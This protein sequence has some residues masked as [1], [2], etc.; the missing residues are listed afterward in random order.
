MPAGTVLG[1]AFVLA[2]LLGTTGCSSTQTGIWQ[3]PV[4]PNRPEATFNATA[5]Q[6]GPSTAP[7]NECKGSYAGAYGSGAYAPG[8]ARTGAGSAPVGW[9]NYRLGTGDKIRV[10]VLQDSEFS[11]DY[12]VDQTGHVSARMLGP[13]R[14]AGMTTDDLAA[15][16]RD[17]YKASGYLVAPRLSV[18]LVAARPFYVLG[19]AARNGSFPYVACLRVIQ[20]VA[21][22]GGFTRRAGKTRVTIRRFYSTAA[23]EEY[24]NEDTLVEPGDVIRIPERWF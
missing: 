17:S 6:V 15:M 4:P 2:A 3:L 10:V 11:G 24:V 21:I 16:L 20:A 22:A 8:T 5:P 23:E 13:V 18:E 12:E 14:V 19:E 1:P 7:L 9:G